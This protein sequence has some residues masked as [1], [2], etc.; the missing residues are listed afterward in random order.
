MASEIT[1]VND[2]ESLVEA[3]RQKS[4]RIEVEGKIANLPSVKLPAG[5]H[6]RG[7]DANAEL[8]FNEGTPGLILSADHEID[9]LRLVTDET[10]I[11]LGLADDAESLGRLTIGNIRTIGRVHL[12]GTQAKRGD[13]RLRNIHVERA[14][15]RLAANRPSGFGVEVLIGGLAVHN[16]SKDNASR[17]TLEAKNLSGGSEKHPIR[18]SGVFFFGG[19]FIPIDAD[20]GRAPAP[21]QKGGSLE[22]K[23]LTTGEIHSDGGIPKG[24]GNLITAGVFLGSGVQ[25]SSIIN[26]GAVTTYGANDMVL[27]NWGDVSSWVAHASITSYGSSGIGFVNF[28]NIETLSIESPIETHGPGARGF[29][30][31]DGT[32]K[33][34]EFQSIVTHGDGA[35]G[36]QLSKPFGTIKVEKDIR[37]K[38]GEGDSLVRGKVVH[39]KAHALS[40]KVGVRGD[41]IK[42]GGQIIAENTSISSLDFETPAQTVGKIEADGKLIT[43]SCA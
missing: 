11:A 17:W 19:S 21:T 31:Y 20:P 1:R 14:D 5:T 18:G 23:L 25:A 37:T 30:L 38:G 13:L 43:R 24:I 35:I 32:L 27:D 41:V 4:L 12:E 15:A 7:V 16:A 6:L 28:G 34:A 42:V 2:K 29:N 36:M 22:V 10:Q 39:L 26:E 9:N 40:L 33:T 3:V 8:H